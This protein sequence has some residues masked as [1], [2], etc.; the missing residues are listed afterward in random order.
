MRPLLRQKKIADRPGT[1]A[2]VDTSILRRIEQKQSSQETPS[3]TPQIIQ[4]RSE[5]FARKVMAQDQ[6]VSRPTTPAPATIAKWSDMPTK[7]FKVIVTRKDRSIANESPSVTDYASAVKTYDAEVATIESSPDFYDQAV[8]IV[9]EVPV[10]DGS[11]GD[12]TDTIPIDPGLMPPPTPAPITIDPGLMP[13]PTP[14]P[15]TTSVVVDTT[16]L[17]T[18]PTVSEN[19]N[20]MTVD[21]TVT[22]VVVDPGLVPPPAPVI[23]IDPGLQPTAA[24]PGVPGP[25]YPQPVSTYQT[26]TLEQNEWVI[27]QQAERAVASETMSNQ[28]LLG[29]GLV[30][31]AGAMYFSKK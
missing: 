20:A 1:S 3:R 29:V 12:I 31:L 21:T 16:P 18:P 10:A 11:G 27:R 17:D 19:Y 28:K 25:A 5:A 6:V 22:E 30:A 2:D 13:P 23:S 26:Q 15:V 7:S 9:P 4:S 8:P 14:A 24:D